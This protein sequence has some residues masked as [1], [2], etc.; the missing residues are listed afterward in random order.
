MV[1]MMYAQSGIC[2]AII[3][4]YTCILLPVRHLKESVLDMVGFI[5]VGIGVHSKFT[6]TS[7]CLAVDEVQEA[8][9]R[10]EE[11]QSST[12]YGNGDM[13]SICLVEFMKEDAVS[14]LTSCKH[15]FHVDCIDKWKDNLQFTCPLC[16][17]CFVHI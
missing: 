16:R 12:C 4:F 6:V 14:Q 11:L 13:C 3:I 2:M 5:L 8:I 15:V 7:T 1:A 9:C 10:F 17:S